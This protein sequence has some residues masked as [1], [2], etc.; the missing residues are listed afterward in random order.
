MNEFLTERYK[1]LLGKDFR[2][3]ERDMEKPCPRYIRVNTLRI[4]ERE[5]KKRLE[6]KEYVLRKKMNNCFRIISSRISPG[7]TI[8]HL[9]GYYMVQDWTSLL[10]PLCLEPEGLVWDMCASPG[11]KTSHLSELMRNKG[12]LLATDKGRMRALFYNTMRMCCSNVII[13]K[14]DAKSIDFEFDKILL[15]APCTGTGMIRKTKHVS[16][17][18]Q[19]E[20]DYLSNIQKK[21][22][23]KAISSLKEGG[24]LVYSTCSMEPEENEMIVQHALNNGMKIEET[25]FGNTGIVDPFGYELDKDIKKTTRIWPNESTGFFVAK[26]VKK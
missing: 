21:L 14:R 25:G 13:Y 10:P 19:G 15:D 2:I 16:D 22:I 7:A 18:S 4:G 5:L 1:E 3:L 23:E 6:E 17:I 26:L 24:T 8:E 11:G 9:S 12:V 20:I